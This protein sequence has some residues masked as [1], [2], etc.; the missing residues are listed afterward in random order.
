MAGRKPLSRVNTERMP[1]RF[2]A[3]PHSVLHSAAYTRLS[4]TARSLLIE[5]GAQL[6]DYNNGLLRCTLKQMRPRGFGSPATIAKAKKELL[7]AQLIYETYK[8]HRPNKASLY[9]V[10]WHSL[11][12]NPKFDPGAY[13]DFRKGAYTDPPVFKPKPTRQELYDRHRDPNKS[14]CLT[15]QSVAGTPSIASLSVAGVSSL[16]SSLVAVQGS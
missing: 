9:A 1:G 3:L 10:T 7:E 2:L 15:T 8:G 4:N 12:P 6:A 13:E 14:A 16:D 11:H 5:F